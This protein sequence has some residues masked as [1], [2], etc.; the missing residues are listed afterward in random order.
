MP[1]LLVN[2][3]K[4]LLFCSISC[5]LFAQKTVIRNDFYWLRYNNVLTLN[6]KLFWVNEFEERRF[7]VNNN[8]HN[9]TAHS[10]L[11]Y[12]YLPNAEITQGVTFSLQSPQDPESKSTLRVPEIRPFQET[13][14]STALNTKLNMVQRLR[15]DNRFVRKNNGLVLLDG[16]DFNLRFRYRLQAVY[17][18][19]KPENKHPLTFKVGNEIMLNAGKRIVYNQFDQNRI[20]TSVE[21]AFNKNFAFELGYI[22]W[23]QQRSV[24]NLF[25]SRN[26]LRMTLFHRIKL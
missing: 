3:L 4:I 21:Y 10:H 11:H 15:I 7:F 6:Q 19:S 8:H 22:H 13:V 17:R 5:Q 23:Y 14:Y 25:Y 12:R 9:F 18:P 20:D 24:G 2:T 16:Y 26:V 1:K